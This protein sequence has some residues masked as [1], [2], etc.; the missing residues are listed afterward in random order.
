MKNQTLVEADIE[1]GLAVLDKLDA[2]YAAAKTPKSIRSW[3]SLANSG[4][5]VDDFK[6]S[7]L[8]IFDA[9]K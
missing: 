1:A 2:H 4:I 5:E 6:V 7:R 9:D 3:A 8:D